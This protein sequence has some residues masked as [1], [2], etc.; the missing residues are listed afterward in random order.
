[1]TSKGISTTE[2]EKNF[3][4]TSNEEQSDSIYDATNIPQILLE[5]DEKPELT[6]EKILINIFNKFITPGNVDMEYSDIQIHQKKIKLLCLQ[7]EK[8]KI[9]Y[10]L[11]TKIRSLIKKYREKLFELPNIIELREKIYQKY[12]HKFIH[13][14][15]YSYLKLNFQIY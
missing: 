12:L 2:S 5:M 15:F 14:Y 10:I 3:G 6:I 11:L 4:E 13:L 1:M 8:S 7:Q 9:V